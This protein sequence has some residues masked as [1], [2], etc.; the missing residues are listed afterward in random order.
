VTWKSF[1]FDVREDGVAVLTL[2]RPERL[3]AI[4]LD[5]YA[6][7]VELAT[8]LPSMRDVRA[9][10]LTGR[11]KGFCSGGDIDGIMGPL[12]AG[13]MERTLEFTRTTCDVVR[14]LRRA[15]QPVIAA[16]NGTAAGAGA[17]LLLASDLCV[18]AEGAK[19]HFLFAKVGLTGADMGAAWMLP[20][21]VGERRAMEALL[22]GDGIPAQTALD[23]GLANRVVPAAEVLPLALEWASRLASGPQE[24]LRLT[25]RAIH[26]EAS[27]SLDSA[28]DY[29]ALAQ[30][31]Q[32]R[33]AD[34]REFFESH[35]EK[36]DPKWR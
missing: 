9:L 30:A 1:A 25:K 26:A 15:P 36:R 29:E 33:A 24:A 10:V 20:R 13:D 18:L 22:F 28:L 27:M 4:T 19:I 35:A 31:T 34:H 17:V 5:V 32:L 3:N 21:V 12:L 11:G 14:L 8:R 16:V 23:W 2:D 7:L 6:E